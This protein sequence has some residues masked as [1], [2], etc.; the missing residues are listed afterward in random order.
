ML[1]ENS[2]SIKRRITRQTARETRHDV[3]DTLIVSIIIHNQLNSKNAIQ[4]TINYAAHN[5]IPPFP[6]QLISCFI[7]VSI[8]N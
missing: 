8:G 2:T 7:A 4:S 5:Y 6:W 1:Y 3:T